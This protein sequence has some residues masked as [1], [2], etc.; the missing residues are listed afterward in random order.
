MDLDHLQLK[1]SQL[2][3]KYGYFQQ[4]VK[5]QH[6]QIQEIHE[7]VSKSNDFVTKVKNENEYLK[8]RL[9]KVEEEL[10]ETRKENE[11]LLEKILLLSGC[12]LNEEEAQSWLS[13]YNPAYTQQLQT[14]SELSQSQKNYNNKATYDAIGS[15]DSMRSREQ[16]PKSEDNK[17]LATPDSVDGR[18]CNKDDKYENNDDLQESPDIYNSDEQISDDLSGI[19]RATPY[20]T[21]KQIRTVRLMDIDQEDSE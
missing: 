10:V 1:T 2:K 19:R 17:F 20:P 7:I 13:P 21:R 4:N 11:K 15:Q 8:K 6:K 18:V 12:N 9:M 14:Q 5:N 3:R 16:T